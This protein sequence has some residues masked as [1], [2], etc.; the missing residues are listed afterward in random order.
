MEWVDAAKGIAILLVALHHSVILLGQNGLLAGPWVQ[1]TVALQVL[2]MPLFF[3]ASGLFAGSVIRRTWPHLW[4]S[5][6]SLLVWTFLLWSVLRFAYFSVVPMD[7]RPE[8]NNPWLLLLAPVLPTSGLWFLHA[9]VVFFVLAKLMQGRISPLVQLVGSGALSVLFLSLP[10]WNIS[11]SGMGMYLFFFLAGCHLKDA[12]IGWVTARTWPITLGL[13]GFFVIGVAALGLLNLSTFGPLAF[14]VRVV[15]VALG[16][17]LAASLR[18][19]LQRA[20]QYLGQ[21]TLPIYVAHVILIAALTTMLRSLAIPS[22]LQL[23]LP[24]ITAGAS[25]TVSLALWISL[26]RIPV[27]RCAYVV[28]AWFSR[29]HA[30][31]SV[32]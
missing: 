10:M 25:V 27:S 13:A 26:R 9:L 16:F 17:M 3:A 4:S 15:A 21:N 7:A 22:A 23:G 32:R 14:A 20:L 1:A 19:P 28:P 12:V 6:L 8:E 29:D 2:R 24:L 11:W 5:R 30:A 31:L 18:G